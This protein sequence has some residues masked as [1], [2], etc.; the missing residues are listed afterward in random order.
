ML[1]PFVASFVALLNFK[2]RILFGKHFIFA[3]HY[4]SFVL[5]MSSLL[6][7]LTQKITIPAEKYFFI[8]LVTLGQVIYFAIAHKKV[9]EDTWL[10]TIFKSCVGIFLINFIIQLYRELVDALALATI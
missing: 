2:K 7:I 5:L 8:T 1:L 3:T 10:L 6:F 9:Y 4:F